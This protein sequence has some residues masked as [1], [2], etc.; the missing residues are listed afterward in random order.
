[1]KIYKK[2]YPKKIFSSVLDITVEFL[3]KN[4]IK[5]LL[6]DV[7][8]TLIDYDDNIVVGLEN[9]IENLKQNGIKFCILSNT[10]KKTKAEK[11]AKLL[12]IPYIF[13]AIKPFKRGFKKAKK[14]INVELNENI[15]VVGDQVMTDSYGANRCGMYS[16]LVEPV[17]KHKDIIV[18]KI[19]RLIE[20]KILKQY[21]KEITQKE[22]NKCT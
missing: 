6:L 12:G 2:F 19:N 5:A 8:N 4:N 18:T 17:N 21:Y 13:F 15:A 10:N 1:M 14:I 16:I 22:E 7:D 9:W 11:M 3:E 20:R